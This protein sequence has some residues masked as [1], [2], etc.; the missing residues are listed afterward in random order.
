M[1]ISRF[2]SCDKFIVHAHADTRL[3]SESIFYN[4]WISPRLDDCYGIFVSSFKVDQI[5][6]RRKRNSDE[7]NDGYSRSKAVPFPTIMG[8]VYIAFLQ[9]HCV[10]SCIYPFILRY[11]VFI[12]CFH[13]CVYFSLFDIDSWIF[14]LCSIFLV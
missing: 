3:F 8:C 5:Y 12:G 14:L 9:F 2:A 11:E 7:R 1:S 13:F 10:Y 4:S 6:S